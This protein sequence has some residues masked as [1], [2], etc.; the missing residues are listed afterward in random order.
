MIAL[1]GVIAERSVSA[2]MDKETFVKEL[3]N[4]IDILSD[5]FSEY[6]PDD[7]ANIDL[8]LKLIRTVPGSPIEISGGLSDKELDIYVPQKSMEIGDGRMAYG[9]LDNTGKYNKGLSIVID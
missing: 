2:K 9:V 3:K 1:A 6:L 8:E 7:I 5:E 4:L